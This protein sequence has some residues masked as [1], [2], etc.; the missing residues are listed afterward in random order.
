MRAPLTDRAVTPTFPE[1]IIET[2]KDLK[3]NIAAGPYSIPTEIIDLIQINIAEPLTKLINVSIAN[4]L[5]FENLKDSKAIPVFQTK[6]TLLDCN[7]YRPI[8]LLSNINKIIEKL[9]HKRIYSFLCKYNCIYIKLGFRKH[10]STI[11]A[12][13]GITEH[14]RYALDNN[15]NN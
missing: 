15:D 1:E 14:I 12:H 5:Y 11:H 4:A 6:G 13:I 7:N 3:S 2:I 8:S 10:H 9:M